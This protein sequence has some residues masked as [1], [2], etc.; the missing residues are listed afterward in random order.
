MSIPAIKNVR[1]VGTQ[2]IVELFDDSEMIDTK[3]VLPE[4]TKSPG[5]PQGYIVEVGPKVDPE[6]GLKDGQRVVLQGSFVPLPSFQ[7]RSSSRQLAATEPHTIK[8]I[9]EE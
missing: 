3:L 2:V 9:L 4:G 1:A 7:G 5:A 8:A 6:W